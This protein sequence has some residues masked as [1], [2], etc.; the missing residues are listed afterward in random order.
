MVGVILCNSLTLS[1]YDYKDR[2]SLSVY[3]QVLDM[4]NLVFTAIF[5]VEASL[6]I[7]A[8]GFIIH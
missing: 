3:N 5:I 2:D 6:K 4:I 8:K 1:L 7:F